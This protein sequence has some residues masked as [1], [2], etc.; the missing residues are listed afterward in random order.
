MESNLSMNSW[1]KDLWNLGMVIIDVAIF[2]FY[3]F[4]I[5][6]SDSFAFILA[7]RCLKLKLFL[8][9]SWI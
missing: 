3:D 4:Y 9:S 7:M 8:I 5:Y 1:E 2:N 6:G